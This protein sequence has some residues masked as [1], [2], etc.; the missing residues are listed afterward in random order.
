MKHHG[1][2]IAM[3]VLLLAGCGGPSAYQRV[4]R[5]PSHFNSKVYSADMATTWAA[6]SRAVLALNFA[7][8]KQDKEQGLLQASR[9]FREGKRTT[10]LA[11]HLTLQAEPTHQTRVYVSATETAEKVFTRSHTRFF[12]WIIPLPGGGGTE[13]NRVTEGERTIEE[14]RFYDSLFQAIDQELRA[15]AAA[16]AT[17]AA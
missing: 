17:P 8:E 10:H 9:H 6:A 4:F 15:A 5:E 2:I 14:K 12:L 7:I 13:A 1:S 11:L 3:A 16:A